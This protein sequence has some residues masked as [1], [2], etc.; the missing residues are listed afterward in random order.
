[1]NSKRTALTFAAAGTVAGVAGLVFLA[2][3]AGAGEAPPALPPISADQLVESV[4]TK[5]DVPALGGSVEMQNNLGLPIPG[6]P[7]SM[8]GDGD[9]VRVYTDGHGRGRIS[10]PNRGGETTVVDDGKTVWVWDSADKTV[11][12]T[13]HGAG[14]KH[15]P[16]EGKFADPA[17]A[18]RE[19]VNAMQ[20]DSTVE[21]DGTARV[22]DRPVY[23]LVLAPKPTERTLLREI[24]V[25]IDSETRVPLQFEVLANGQAD[26]AL[27]VGFTEFDNGPQ[28]AS[29]FRFTPPEGA[30]V[31][32]HEPDEK[33][34]GKSPDELFS[35][36]DLD[37]VGNGW[38]TVLTGKLPK[39]ALTMPGGSGEETA[40]T[41]LSRIGKEVHGDFG[42]G[43][44]ISSKVG[45]ALITE[46]GRVA[47]GA[48]P[49]QVLTE[50]LGK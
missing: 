13:P 27:K 15:T 26:P 41:F 3:P 23:Q 17:T 46:D 47:I 30:K 34:H 7:G 4:L 40:V 6:L 9:Q 11:V 38:D 22:A 21:V 29:L 1:M 16:L 49:E 18:A 45:T 42:T 14:Q 35:Q 5:N 28:D 2:S 24:R 10:V 32:V 20:E 36:L 43:W 19:L 39:D 48:V 25:S 12:K 37:T 44:A 31:T 8:G 50:A 33:I